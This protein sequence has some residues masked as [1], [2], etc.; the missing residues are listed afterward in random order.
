[1]CAAKYFG[2]TCEQYDATDDCAT[3][4]A[5]CGVGGDCLDLYVRSPQPRFLN[6]SR[7]IPS[8]DRILALTL[9]NVRI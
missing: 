9:Y 4:G 7:V 2:D 5:C 3:P 8:T 6:I 1:M